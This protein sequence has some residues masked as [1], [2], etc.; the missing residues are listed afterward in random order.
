MDAHVSTIIYF[1]ITRHQGKFSEVSKNK[2]QSVSLISKFRI[3]I[4]SSY[5]TTQRLYNNG[6]P[7]GG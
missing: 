7:L 1:C 6:L 2:T 5:V 4:T 3:L